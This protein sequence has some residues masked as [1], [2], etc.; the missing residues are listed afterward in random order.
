MS[1]DRWAEE[2]RAALETYGRTSVELSEV[3]GR[4]GAESGNTVALHW[5]RKCSCCADENPRLVLEQFSDASTARF[6]WS[7]Q[8]M[9]PLHSADMGTWLELGG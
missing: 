8:E 4:V 1:F 2:V 6:E 3:M 5:R 9:K 7:R